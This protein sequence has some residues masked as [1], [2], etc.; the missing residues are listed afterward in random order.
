M[1][2]NAIEWNVTSDR[3]EKP[4][5]IKI[6]KLESKAFNRYANYCQTFYLKC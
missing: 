2:V 4:K 3:S 1:Y 6:K 5:G